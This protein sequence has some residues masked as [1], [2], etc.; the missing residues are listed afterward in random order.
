MY[1]VEFLW[2]ISALILHSKR[3]DLYTWCNLHSTA[4][5]I[6]AAM[7]RLT[8]QSSHPQHD[9]NMVQKESDHFPLLL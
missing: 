6:F 3:I 5:I 1:I 7:S 2:H 8:S 9:F 4:E